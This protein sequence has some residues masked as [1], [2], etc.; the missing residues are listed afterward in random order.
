MYPLLFIA[1]NNIK[2]HKGEVAI[3]FALIFLSATLLFSS[4][5]MMLSGEKSM[6]ECEKKNHSSDL[7]VRAENIS[8]EDMKK[9]IE[10]VS[11]TEKCEILKAVHT[12]ADCFY[13][14]MDPEDAMSNTYYFFD[15]SCQT[16]LNALP[17]EDRKSVV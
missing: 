3:L 9:D 12:T 7:F 6:H 11:A 13:G 8:A 16:E 15:A 10:T 5:S 1:K 14:S 17:E 4:I 2:K